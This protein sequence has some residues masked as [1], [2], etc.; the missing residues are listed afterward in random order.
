MESVSATPGE[1]LAPSTIRLSVASQSMIDSDTNNFPV[2]I[3]NPFPVTVEM[4]MRLVSDSPN[5]IRVTPFELVTLGPGEHRAVSASPSTTSNGAVTMRAQL[6]A[7]QGTAFGS[8]VLVEITVAGLRRVGRT[9]IVI[10]GTV[11]VG[12]TFLRIRVVQ[13]ERAK[14]NHEQ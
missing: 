4:W 8:V 12:G 13:G 10:S 6:A 11:M 1:K 5:R 2:T 3:D 14:E 7:E 9:I